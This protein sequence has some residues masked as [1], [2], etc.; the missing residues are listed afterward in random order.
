MRSVIKNRSA[1]NATNLK[2][3]EELCEWISADPDQILGWTQLCHKSGFTKEQLI[4]I[5]QLFKQTTPMSFVRN[6]RLHH[7]RNHLTDGQPDLFDNTQKTNRDDDQ[8]I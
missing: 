5:F 3:L 8:L 4:E 1:V 2:K 6:T 7:K